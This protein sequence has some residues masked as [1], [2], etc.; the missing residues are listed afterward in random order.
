M[1]LAF[2][3]VFEVRFDQQD[4]NVLRIPRE[5]NQTERNRSVYF[6]MCAHE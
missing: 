5:T 4:M 3:S 6:S 2:L 1:W